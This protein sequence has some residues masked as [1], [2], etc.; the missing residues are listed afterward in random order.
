M[1]EHSRTSNRRVHPGPTAQGLRRHTLKGK[2]MYELNDE[3]LGLIAGGNDC[4]GETSSSL[5]CPI[6]N[7]QSEVG[8]VVDDVAGAINDFGSWL[9]GAIY[10]ATH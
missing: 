3:K 6:A 10:D 8:K 5:Q 4:S 2:S 1:A 9:G 7:P